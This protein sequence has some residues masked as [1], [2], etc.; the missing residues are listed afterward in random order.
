MSIDINKQRNENNELEISI[1]IPIYKVERY[2]VKCLES[3][4]AQTFKAYEIILIDDGSPDGCGTI[5]D[6]YA[7][8]HHNINVIHQI[9]GGLANA[10]NRGLA[11][12]QGKF[13]GFVDS[14]DYIDKD[15]FSELHNAIIDSG[16]DIAICNFFRVENNQ[17]IKSKQEIEAGLFTTEEL[18]TSVA[19]DK[20]GSYMWNKLYRR[21]LFDGLKFKDGYVFEDFYIFHELFARTNKIVCLRECLY[22][23]VFNENGILAN[24]RIRTECNFLLA[25]MERRRFLQKDFPSLEKYTFDCYVRAATK[26]YFISRYL[27]REREALIIR[28]VLLGELKKFI[29]SSDVR[30]KN[31][32]HL[33]EVLMDFNLYQYC[34]PKCVRKKKQKIIDD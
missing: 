10:R 9:N 25:L 16:A 29:L 17:V 21:E 12:A 26:V 22:Y 2:L 31:K 4:L 20:I 32:I 23:Y 24:L 15:M 18:W 5:C 30:I 33:L 8:K 1:I 7:Q 6:E 11:V 13:I 28:M 27:H 14:D 3:V 19:S 34:L